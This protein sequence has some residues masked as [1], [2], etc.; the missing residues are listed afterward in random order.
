VVPGIGRNIG[1]VPAGRIAVPAMRTA[2]RTGR[3]RRAIDVLLQVLPEAGIM[4][5]NSGSI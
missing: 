4:A 3:A 5:G 1:S 2:Y